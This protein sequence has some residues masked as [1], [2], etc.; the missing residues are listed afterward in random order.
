MWFKAKKKKK[1]GCFLC[2]SEGTSL[3]TLFGLVQEQ[4][5]AM[6][7]KP[8]V[9]VQLILCYSVN[10]NNTSEL[11]QPFL[12]PILKPCCSTQ[13]SSI[14]PSLGIYH[15]LQFLIRFQQDSR[16]T[17][18][19]AEQCDNDSITSHSKCEVLHFRWSLRRGEWQKQLYLEYFTPA[20]QLDCSKLESWTEV[21]TSYR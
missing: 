7:L 11:N 3:I 20:S 15:R 5:M 1:D 12:I 16:Y 17:C 8:L 9:K 18:G 19:C 10:I 6:I 21:G 2:F 13:E 14:F 4:N